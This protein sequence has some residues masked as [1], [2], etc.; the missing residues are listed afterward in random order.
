MNK[1]QI[2]RTYLVTYSRADLE[3][4]P[5]R[6]SFGKAIAEFFKKGSSQVQVQH[7]ASALDNHQ[8]GWKLFHVVVKLNLPKPWLSVK[9]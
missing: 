7:F 8:N 2:K 3:L 9:Y 5:T 1:K 6:E 4:F